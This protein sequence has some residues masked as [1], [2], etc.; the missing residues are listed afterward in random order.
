MDRIVSIPELAEALY[1]ESTKSRCVSL[2]RQCRDGVIEAEKIGERWY[3]NATRQFPG[4]FDG[5]DP[6]SVVAPEDE[7]R[8][9]ST[10]SSA[11][12][13]ELVAELL[14][15]VGFVPATG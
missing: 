7:P 9:A 15:R 3:V 5:R 2:A 14:A 6:R 4:L 13:E 10:L 8:A 1:G 12:T 11:T